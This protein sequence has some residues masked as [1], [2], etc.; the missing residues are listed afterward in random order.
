MPNRA[1]KMTPITAQKEASKPLAGVLETTA[2]AA[3]GTRVRCGTRGRNAIVPA[4]STTV[5]AKLV[6]I[7]SAE[8]PE[9]SPAIWKKSEVAMNPMLPKT[10]IRPY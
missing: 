2:H 4:A 3:C 5:A 8:S 1:R 9:I 6:R 10:R 7:D